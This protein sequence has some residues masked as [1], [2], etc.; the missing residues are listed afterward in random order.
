MVLYLEIFNYSYDSACFLVLIPIV[1]EG[2]DL[3]ALVKFLV[4]Y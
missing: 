1:G 2:M 4:T 3:V